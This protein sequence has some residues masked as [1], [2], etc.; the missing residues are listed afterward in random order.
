MR[1]TTLVRSKAKFSSM[2]T[3]VSSLSVQIAEKEVSAEPTDP[4]LRPGFSNAC[5]RKVYISL[6][7]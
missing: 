4:S 7:M 2:I 5:T 3:W 1:S 6:Q